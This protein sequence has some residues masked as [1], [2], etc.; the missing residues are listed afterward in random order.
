MAAGLAGLFGWGSPKYLCE[1]NLTNA[2]HCTWLTGPRYVLSYGQVSFNDMERSNNLDPT[3][4]L[5]ALSAIPLSVSMLK[6]VYT[7]G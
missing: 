2:V 6:I 3:H 4:I 1:C 7:N 5:S